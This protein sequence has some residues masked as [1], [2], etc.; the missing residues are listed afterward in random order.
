[1]DL[2]NKVYAPVMIITCNRYAHFK[3]CIESLRKNTLAAETEIFIGLDYPPSAEY[4]DG[5]NKIK[6]YIE[7]GIDGFKQVNIIKREY[8]FGSQENYFDLETNIVMPKYDRWIF[9]E[10]DNVFSIDFLDY[11]N[12][13]LELYKN[14]D[15]IFS[16]CGHTY[17]REE[18]FFS[19]KEGYNF[20]RCGF[21][22][23]GYGVWRDKWQDALNTFSGEW[24]ETMVKKTSYID[25]FKIPKRI[26]HNLV[27]CFCK[28][29]WKIYDR[30]LTF[31]LWFC[32]KYQLFPHSTFVKNNG[33]DGSGECL[34]ND[35]SRNEGTFE[36]ETSKFETYKHNPK[37]SVVGKDYYSSFYPYGFD[38]NAEIIYFAMH[39]LGFKR[40][41]TV[42]QRLKII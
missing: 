39:L 10:D 23:W 28:D 5:Y 1:M 21:N 9:T 3:A 18:A 25:S 14:D 30:T 31:Y 37:F 13:Y 24:I 33:L 32:Q 34:V 11:M 22:A 38:R 7:S 12:Y 19:G 36:N 27:Y 8:N 15:K 20:A 42:L 40:A 29:S 35:A 4:E 17:P 6:D 41:K 26:K 16:I 2:N